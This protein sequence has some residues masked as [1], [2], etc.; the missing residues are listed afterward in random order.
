M[1]QRLFT[2][3]I[4][5]LLMVLAGLLFFGY[6]TSCAWFDKIPKMY[7][8]D[9]AQTVGII[10]PD[11]IQSVW[12]VPDYE[13]RDMFQEL[14]KHPVMM[15]EGVQFYKISTW[16]DTAGFLA[17]MRSGFKFSLKTFNVCPP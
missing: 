12:L 13:S 7:F 17:A 5:P 8:P 4:Q 11:G 16:Q 14:A 2:T 10:D 3:K 1:N 15:V 9:D 6:V